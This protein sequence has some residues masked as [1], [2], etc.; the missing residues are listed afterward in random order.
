[1]AFPLVQLPLEM[2]RGEASGPGMAK[3]EGFLK[4]RLTWLGFVVPALLFGFKGLHQYYP[5]FPDVTTDIDLNGLFPQY[6]YNQMTFFH[7]YFSVAAV[8]FFYLLPTDLLFSLWF[9][10]LL[11]KV[12]EI[13]AGALGYETDVMPMYGCKTFIGYQIIGCYLVLVG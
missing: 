5:S 13:G 8:G 4:N 10:F 11:T 1:L 7:L 3:T 6:P 9:F 2:I 12:E